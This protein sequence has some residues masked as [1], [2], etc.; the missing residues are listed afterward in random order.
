MGLVIG[1]SISHCSIS[2]PYPIT[3]SSNNYSLMWVPID[4]SSSAAVS[5][6]SQAMAGS[7]GI[8]WPGVGNNPLPL[9]L[10]SS[11][12]TPQTTTPVGTAANISG[13]YH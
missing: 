1:F 11:N 10:S 8:V 6:A 2:Y 4:G 13:T 7:G 3:G 9:P 5:Q 12:I